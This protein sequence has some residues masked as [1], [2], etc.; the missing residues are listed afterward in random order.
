MTLNDLLNSGFSVA[1]VTAL[2]GLLKPVLE[3]LGGPFA[4][5]SGGHDAAFRILNVVLQL[6]CIVGLA[7]SNGELDLVRLWPVYVATA[8]AQALGSH[9]LYRVTRS[10]P[11]EA[12]LADAVDV[13]SSTTP[14]LYNR[15]EQGAPASATSNAAGSAATVAVTSSTPAAA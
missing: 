14:T 15:A 6:A 5:S 8:L 11:D 13:L 9:G 10:T 4:K 1:L 3:S 7:A 2:L 12:I